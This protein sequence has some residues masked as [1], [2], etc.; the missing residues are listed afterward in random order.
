VIEGIRQ[1]D[2]G[3]DSCIH[4]RAALLRLLSHRFCNGDNNHTQAKGRAVVG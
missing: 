4:L 3:N 2:G 1:G